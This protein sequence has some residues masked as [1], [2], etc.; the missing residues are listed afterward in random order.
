[1]HTIL[2]QRCVKM[3]PDIIRGYQTG[4]EA[5]HG[6]TGYSYLVTPYSEHDVKQ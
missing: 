1:M 3:T 2:Q 5:K 6:T 4:E